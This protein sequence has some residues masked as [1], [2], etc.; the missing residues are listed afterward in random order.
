MSLCVA[1]GL[2]GFRPTTLQARLLRREVGR[3]A[4]RRP[5]RFFRNESS[6]LGLRHEPL[7]LLGL[8]GGCIPRRLELLQL[9][10]PSGG[11]RGALRFERL[12]A[13][14]ELVFLCLELREPGLRSSPSSLRFRRFGRL[15]L[16]FGV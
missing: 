8:L 1:F 15:G 2:F 9:L 14:E 5:F 16:H 7:C 4:F 13:S 10:G 6:P 11:P 3:L 12:A